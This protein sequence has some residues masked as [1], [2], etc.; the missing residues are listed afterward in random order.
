[1]KI[2]REE[3]VSWWI[4]L[5]TLLAAII[6][7]ITLSLLTRSPTVF[8]TSVHT[9]K[10]LLE[11]RILYKD[12]EKP[13]T[14]GYP[15]WPPIF[16]YSLALWFM[17]MGSSDFAAKLF[18]VT[19]TIVAGYL[20]YYVG[21][22]F[23]SPKHS[24]YAMVLFF[25][26]PYTML[27]SLGGHFENYAGIFFLLAILA[28]KKERVSLGGVALGIAIM[29]KVFPGLL[30]IVIFPFWIARREYRPTLLLFITTAITISIIALPF[31]IICPDGF[32]YYIF[33]FHGE[34][35]TGGVSIYYYWLPWLFE[36]S[37]LIFALQI[38]L[39]G[40]LA[41]LLFILTKKHQTINLSSILIL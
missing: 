29:I 9:A 32:R 1:M 16:P 3:H 17:F 18:C 26:N 20:C 15:A 21:K 4:L 14:T 40:F 24:Y 19:S 10:Q 36:N 5:L 8:V 33:D 27:I 13:P 12:V 11:G 35:T 31:L 2:A 41:V 37:T 38:I 30:L 25:F 23:L 39:L 28:I 34:R 22:E 6:F 7:H